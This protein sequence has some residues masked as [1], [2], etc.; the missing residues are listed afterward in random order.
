MELWNSAFYGLN[1]FMYRINDNQREGSDLQNSEITWFTT[2]IQ[3]FKEFSLI[4]ACKWSTHAACMFDKVETRRLTPRLE[5]SCG[6][7]LAAWWICTVFFRILSDSQQLVMRKVLIANISEMEC[8]SKC[9]FIFHS[10]RFLALSWG[11]LSYFRVLRS[12][13]KSYF[14]QQV[15]RC[16]CW[17]VGWRVDRSRVGSELIM[18]FTLSLNRRRDEISFLTEF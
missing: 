13:W 12:K 8:P 18:N 16:E 9:K 2:I 1:W 17:K 3:T 5:I 11:A 15:P 4:S 6:F 10:R 14:M 7:S